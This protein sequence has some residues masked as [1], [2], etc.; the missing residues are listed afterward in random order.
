MLEYLN[1]PED[2]RAAFWDDGWFRSGDV[3]L[4]DENGYLYIVDR[5]KDMIITGG[6]NVYPREV[7]EVI[8]KR[9]EVELCV[10]VGIPDKE[11]GERVTAF[12]VAK[13]GR[14]IDPGE[15]KSFLKSRLSPFKVP[16]D[17][18]EVN[19][20]PKSPAGKILKR[21]VRKQFLEGRLG[22][23]EKE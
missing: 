22:K 10:V 3:G 5:I 7:E 19:E 2:T 18:I 13:P 4:L 6:E 20:L 12:I 17:Y 11:W 16:K 1:N 15:L 14:S 21:E 9:P 8:Y 23:V